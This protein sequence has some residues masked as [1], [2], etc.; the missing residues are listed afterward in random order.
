MLRIL[1]LVGTLAVAGCTT[2]SPYGNRH[3]SR[4]PDARSYPASA[5]TSERGQD[6]YRIC[7][8]DR[9]TLTLPTPAVRAHLRHGDHFGAC[10][11][12][13]GRD[14]HRGR[15]DRGRDDDRRHDDDR[16]RDRDDD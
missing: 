16:G 8:N 14:D 10:R 1:A 7:H 3:A 15:G 2:A 4:Y 6:R 5:R 11:S 12:S 9:Q 13:R